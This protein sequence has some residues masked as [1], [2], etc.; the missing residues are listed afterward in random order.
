MRSHASSIDVPRE[1][2]S[3]PVTWGCQITPSVSEGTVSPAPRPR[4]DAWGYLDR[5][6]IGVHH[7]FVGRRPIAANPAVLLKKNLAAIL[8]KLFIR[9]RSGTRI[10]V[11]SAVSGARRTQATER[12]ARV[13]RRAQ[14]G[15]ANE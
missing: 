10:R 14:S 2:I 8:G 6:R 3:L 9:T 15:E 1:P 4:A 13:R 12:S 11:W 7:T 5:Q